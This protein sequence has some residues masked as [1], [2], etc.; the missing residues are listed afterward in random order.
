LSFQKH[1]LLENTL[2]DSPKFFLPET[3]FLLKLLFFNRKYILVR[4]GESV[5]VTIVPPPSA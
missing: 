2:Y 5:D 3:F 1:D 4:A